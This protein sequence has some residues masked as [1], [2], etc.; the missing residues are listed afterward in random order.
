MKK[1][2]QKN[3]ETIQKHSAFLLIKG[4][5]LKRT[6]ETIFGTSFKVGFMALLLAVAVSGCKKEDSQNAS[7]TSE[8]Q[9]SSDRRRNPSRDFEPIN[10]VS[11][12]SSY[13]PVTID[14][15]L[16]NAWGIAFGANGAL[17]IASDHTGEAVIYNGQ[18][19]SLRSPVTI[20]FQGVANGGSPTGIVHNNTLNFIIP[21]NGE[22]AKFIFSAEDG[23]ISA[24]SS[25]NA[26][27]TVADRSGSDAVYKGLAMA[28]SGGSNYLYATN[29]KG[30]K[31]DVFDQ[32]F[33]YVN[34]S[35]IDP[36]IPAGYAPFG[37]E[38]IDGKL[39]V[40]YAKQK[41]PDFKDDES[42]PGHGYI[43]IFNTDGSFVKRFASQGVLNSPWGMAEIP[44]RHDAVLVGN[45]GD[46]KINAFDSNGNSLGNL[47]DDGQDIVIEGLW[48]IKFA[49]SGNNYRDHRKLYFTAGPDEEAH[50]LFGFL[51]QE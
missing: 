48:A 1:K 26:A 8:D 19:Q 17:W 37:I 46:G 10:L 47:K 25:G 18:G 51:R 5:I 32:S 16:N 13:N 11:D 7:A 30:A 31:I 4:S 21:S 23:T 38:N 39:Y 9:N 24:W 15:N 42:G 33:N 36:G 50:G 49:N 20:P 2:G 41:A 22:R 12:T 44:G 45:F 3:Q 34:M 27:V 43:D 40:S 29:F 28:H 6:I 14:S 35:F